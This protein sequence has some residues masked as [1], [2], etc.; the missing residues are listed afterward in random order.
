MS[1]SS[2][3][4][5][6]CLLAAGGHAVA[7]RAAED[8]DRAI[9][10]VLEHHCNTCHSTEK[11]KGDLDLER[12]TS[13]AEI[14]KHPMVWENVLDQ[15]ASN[16]M[17]PKKE[18]P[19]PAAQ[20][21]QLMSWVRGVLDDVALAN[22][23]DPGPV[24]LRRLSNVEYTYTIRDLTGVESLDP[25]RE[26]PVDGA[27]GE[28]FTNTGAALVM[29][30]ALLTKYLDAAKDI[31]A[32]MVLLPDGI[33]F[34]PGTSARDW[35]DETLARIRALYAPF[36]AAE[37]TVAMDLQGSKFDASV[38]GRL[39]VEKYLSALVTHRE[40][41]LTGK[42]IETIAKNNGLS[43]RYLRTLWQALSERTPSSQVLQFVR[44]RFQQAKPGDVSVLVQLIRD[45]QQ[46]LWRFTSVGHI[47]KQNGPKSWQEPVSPLAAQHEIR[48]KLAPRA[49]GSDVVLYLA[50]SDLGDGNEHDFALW[51]NP[52]LVAPGRPDLPLKNVRSVVQQLA[53]KRT[54]MVDNVLQC[55]AAAHEAGSGTDRPDLPALARKHQADP[56]MLGAWLD[57]LGLVSTGRP[58]LG[59]LLTKKMDG[60]RDYAFI[61]GWTGD[62]ALS[63][64]AN[65]SDASVRTPGTMKPHGVAVHPSPK[66]S[67]VVAWR[68]PVSGSMQIRGSIQDAHPECGNGITWALE[69]RRGKARE[70]LA[71]GVSK[72]ASV[73]ELGKFD[74][75]RVTK[76]DAVA[77]VIGPRDGNHVC[78]LTAVDLVMS[79]STHE[80]SLAKDVSSDILAA[81]PHADS[82]GN[83]A[84]WHFVSEDTTTTSS[85]AIPP[86][87]LL[88][89]WLQSSDASQRAHLA[90]QVQDLLRNGPG[91]LP[92]D[93]PDRA[94]H[95]Q[96]TSF[97]GPLL[98]AALRSVQGDVHDES[99]S[100]YGLPST[101]FGSHP[102]GAKVDPLSLCVQ[103]PSVMEV[104]L[105]AALAEGAELVVGARLHP[106]SD[107]E[108]SIQ[109][110]VLDHPP[111]KNSTIVAG[112]SASENANGKW[113][114]NNLRTSNAVPVIVARGSAAEKRMEA[115]FE[116]FRRLFPAA[117]CYTK[118]VP[119]D[120]VVTLTLFH[121]EDD[122]LRRLM[123]DE[124][125]ARELDRL[126][127]D[128]HFISESPLKQVDVFEQL[129]QFAT[130]DA[131]PSAFEPMREPIMQGAEVFRKL[132]SESEPLHV[133]AVIE[134]AEKAWR[135][136][137][138]ASERSEF[139]TLYQKLRKQELPHAA[140]VRMLL[141][142]ALMAPAFLYR[143]ER[144]A[145]GLQAAAVND[146]ELATR[147]SYF[148]WSSAPDEELR[149]LAA[150]GK[151]HQPDVL[152]A[153]AKRMC[154]DSRIRRLAIEFGCQWLHVR[155]LE[156]LDEKSERH[157]P[158]FA[159]LRGAMQEEAARFFI[160]LFQ[161][162]R[163]VL[164]LLDAD[165]SFINGP[166]AEHYGL[167]T[168][169]AGWQRVDGLK[170]QGRGGILGFASTLAKQSGASRTSP[171]L[172]GNWLSEVIL[173]EKLPKPPKGVPILPEEAPAGLTERQLIERHSSD[174]ACAR[175]HQRIDPFGF[176]LEG[177]D[178]IGRS[179]PADTKA[180]LPD[181]TTFT[182]LDGLRTYL[183]TSRRD[184]FLRQFCRKL[185]GY[186]L[187]RS[188]QL[189]DKPLIESMLAALKA[190]QYRVGAALDTVVRSQQFQQVRGRD[191]ISSN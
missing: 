58:H 117:L 143:G 148:F 66:R 91:A 180:T 24:V 37:G 61:K 106:S 30:P 176:A 170:S 94:L 55:L 155:D 39:P 3:L 114:D 86:G 128:L 41:L 167:K 121:R 73:V 158:T 84:V 186:A 152:S 22:A 79:D 161:Q 179:R 74:K 154:K 36:C 131:S 52:R 1:S 92:A 97:N 53:S 141:T 69:A 63:V 19:L 65:S 118:I 85:P 185:L 75:V 134:F 120:E 107:P 51:E 31:A 40:A 191:F 81:N 177:F 160:D 34:S 187:G 173:G 23:G 48:V 13:V 139:S 126:W 15:L 71:S 164:A 153:Q 171:I 83:A 18:P 149:S 38:G 127:S 138:A 76:G 189:S 136:P 119:V 151:L 16:E 137:L 175:C 72:G 17:P 7:V 89:Q 25:A 43:P 99:S 93:S 105:P 26:F 146:W 10:P 168:Q 109:M 159:S 50:A 6:C 145:P 68:S 169:T 54:A 174:V 21:Q 111:A 98:A 14:K 95:A 44:D 144:A 132:Q 142:R 64:L 182:G 133:K 4:K 82:L 172:R 87:S 47:G 190:D 122:Q 113:S 165:Y 35:T 104:R 27:A 67:A 70:I 150:A 166:L 96:I 112:R 103:A 125:Q 183:L 115:A 33:R 181:G 100:L 156:T 101:L 102:T 2:S 60:T 29:S 80:W 5:L 88:S 78:D 12:F 108:A 129:Y 110:Q 56:A 116:D 62:Q 90:Q 162:D 135:R 77:L 9:L 59:P 124:V 32:H 8:F 147:L 20:K 57:Y 28:G 42:S 178:A 46:A 188:V 163:P 140:A 11:Q 49:D 157:F 123:L 130:Q 45:W 184:D